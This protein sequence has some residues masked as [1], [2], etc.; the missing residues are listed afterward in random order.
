MVFPL[1]LTEI[2]SFPTFG[3]FSSTEKEN[4]IYRDEFLLSFRANFL[5]I[6]I[7]GQRMSA[8]VGIKI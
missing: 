7:R 2:V 1:D 6:H 3:R 5:L 4:F 8:Q